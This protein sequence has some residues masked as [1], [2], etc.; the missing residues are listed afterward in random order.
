M[1]LLEKKLIT[2]TALNRYLKYRFD[3]DENLK[4][5]RLKAEIS[6]YKRHSRGHLYFSLKDENSSVNAV[7]FFQ[8]ASKLIFEPKDGSKVIVEGYV[9]IYEPTGSYQVYVTQM[10]EEGLGDL[11]QA[12]EKLKIKLNEA[13]LFEASH[14]RPIPLFPKAVGVITS[15]TGAAVR[16]IINIINRR[17]PL[18]KI[19]VYPALVQ[20]DEAK[21]SIV[22]MIE[23]ANADQLT[24]VLIVGRGGGSIE[25]LWAFNEEMVAKAIYDSKIPIVSAVGHE[26]D[27]TIADFVSDL[28]APTPSGAAELVVPDQKT[29]IDTLGSHS[30]KM[31]TYVN[32]ILSSESRHLNQLLNSYV[33]LNPARIIERPTMQLLHLSDRLTQTRPDKR[34]LLAHESL[35]RLET[36][37]TVVYSDR[38]NKEVIH[39][40][41]MTE[42]LELLNPLNLMKKGYAIVKHQG[43]IKKSV[44]SLQQ[45]DQIEISMV[46]GTLKATID[47]ILKDG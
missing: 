41:N 3:Q 31:R 2:V 39:F 14:K 36:S 33:F 42:K 22:K 44:A 9:S 26:T 10:S 32:R 28:R 19:I 30:Q 12:F 23:K 17:Y 34:L 18:T 5:I 37:L 1:N 4:D 35:N 45:N 7:M 46:D 27:T 15:P 8:N 29:L 40:I 25:D 6:N 11:Y 47:D 21:F 38:I 13:G 20:G 43:N 24:D 16:D